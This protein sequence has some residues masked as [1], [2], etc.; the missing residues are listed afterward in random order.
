[1]RVSWALKSHVKVTM[2][3]SCPAPPR[4]L[5]KGLSPSSLFLPADPIQTRG[6]SAQK[7][8]VQGIKY[9]DNVAICVFPWAAIAVIRMMFT[10]SQE[11]GAVEY[12][13]ELRVHFKK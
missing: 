4:E 1:M 6:S 10:L 11:D 12:P 2:S 9:P 5:E 7:N 8:L 13:G 3:N